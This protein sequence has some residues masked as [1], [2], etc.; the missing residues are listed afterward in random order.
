MR[1][2]GQYLE[3]IHRDPFLCA[4]LASYEN[5][6]GAA[7]GKDVLDYGCGYGW[8]SYMLSWHCRRVTAYDP[9]PERIEFAGRVFSRENIDFVSEEAGL[10]G[11]QYDLVCIFM[12]LPYVGDCGDILTR[13]PGYLK[14]GGMI[15]L[16]Y[17]NTCRALARALDGWASDCG[18]ATVHSCQRYLS[19]AESVEERCYCK[20]GDEEWF[21]A[22]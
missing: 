21:Y 15:M 3:L 2:A 5:A 8:G 4:M 18:F 6:V 13:L 20:N 1:K 10:S 22:L 16:S 17:K 11:K 14:P 19:D 7:A 9:A 12:V